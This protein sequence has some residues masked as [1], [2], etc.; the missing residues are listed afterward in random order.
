VR[1]ERHVPYRVDGAA[2]PEI[3]PEGVYAAVDGARSV[4]DIC[5]VV[6]AGEFEVTRALF[7]LVQAGHVAVR[8]PPLPAREAVE[9]YNR[10]VALILREL[11]A[12]DEGD[13]VREQIAAFA[14]TTGSV[15]A[16]LLA[17][18]VPADDGTFDAAE[19]SDKIA[20]ASSP[21]DAEQRL[22]E[23]LY[24]LASYALFL[25][26]PHLRRMEE[27]RS[28]KPRLSVRVT[29]LLE[30]IAPRPGRRAGAEPTARASAKKRP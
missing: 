9:V 10:A 28:G 16:E 13:T 7:Q 30:P 14:T 3:D 26:R 12:M 17:S 2:A 22:A 4:A 24:E 15:H 19:I 6:G 20:R 27:A 1:S 29:A 5:R 11:D 18:A 8:P 21:R 25:A 23:W